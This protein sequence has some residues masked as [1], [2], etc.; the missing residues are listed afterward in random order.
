MSKLVV[1]KVT[2][3]SLASIKTL[4]K[5]GKVVRLP[6]VIRLTILNAL[7][8][9]LCSTLI[10]ITLLSYIFISSISRLCVKVEN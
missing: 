6:P 4:F 3:L 1:T 7:A 9:L 10:S 2:L 5:I 8:N